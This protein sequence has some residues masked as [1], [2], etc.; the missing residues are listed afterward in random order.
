VYHNGVPVNVEPG[1]VHGNAM[2]ITHPTREDGVGLEGLRFE[3][4]G[5]TS[6]LVQ[7]G[8]VRS[9]NG[10][11]FA[12]GRRWFGTDQANL[13]SFLSSGPVAPPDW[14]SF[15]G[16]VERPAGSSAVSVWLLNAF[17]EPG[18]KTC[19]DDLFLFEAVPPDIAA[20]TGSNALS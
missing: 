20:S 3:L 5:S 6:L 12:L 8:E 19:Y 13:Y 15:S 4:S 17:G 14:I 10:S 1:G 16:T 9:P 2:C 7:G 11:G 18:G